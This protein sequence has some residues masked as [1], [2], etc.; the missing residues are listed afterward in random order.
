MNNENKKLSRNRK[1][2]IGRRKKINDV[3]KLLSNKIRTEKKQKKKNFDKIIQLEIL[4]VRIK[5]ADKPIKLERALRELNKIQV[6]NKNLHEIK[7][8]ILLDSVGA[9]EMVDNLKVVNQIRQTNIR[10]RNINDFEAYINSIDSG[11]DAEDAFFIGHI[12]KINTPIFNKVNRSQYGNCCY[13]KNE[14]FEYR[15]NNCFRTT[16]GYCCVKCVNFI[17]GQDYVQQY[18][19]FI[20][21]EK[22]RSIFMTKARIQP[23]CRANNTNLG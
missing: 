21:K 9:F 12:Y 15:G 23:H 1:K 19:V 7:N 14:I 4:L 2:R 17:T 5:Y 20:R 13:F 8:E 6:I 3:M 10:F 16:K 22:R 18:L 11:Y